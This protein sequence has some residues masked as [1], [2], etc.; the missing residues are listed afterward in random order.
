M[1]ESS[2]PLLVPLQ[3]HDGQ[4]A[5]DREQTEE[6]R[7]RRGALLSH[8]PPHT[9]SSLFHITQHQAEEVREE[10]LS[11]AREK[12]DFQQKNRAVAGAQHPTL[13]NLTLTYYSGIFVP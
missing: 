13:C 6:E 7:V 2:F 8:A 4:L 3:A 11:K 9:P 10:L 5:V 12:K 1:G